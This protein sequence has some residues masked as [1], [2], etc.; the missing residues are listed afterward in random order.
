MPTKR[1]HEIT[2]KLD[3]IFISSGKIDDDEIK[4]HISRYLCVLVSGYLEEAIKIIIRDYS[5]NKS[6]TN[7]SNYINSS[8]SHIT[9]LK[10]NNICTFLNQF[11]SEWK[12]SLD[13]RVSDAERDAIDSLVANRHLIAHGHDVGVSYVRINDWYKNTKSVVNKINEIINT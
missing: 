2:S 11:N 6:H 7:I 10:F 4:S 13:N 12:E 5:S 9:N 3:G 8:T 1:L